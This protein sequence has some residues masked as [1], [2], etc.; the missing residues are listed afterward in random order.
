MTV[1]LMKIMFY[2]DCDIHNDDHNDG[3]NNYIQNSN[4][5]NCATQN[6]HIII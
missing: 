4:K 1:M 3:D 5:D 6:I 2:N